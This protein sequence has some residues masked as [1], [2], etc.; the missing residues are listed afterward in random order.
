[1]S[2][3]AQLFASIPVSRASY[4]QPT[5]SEADQDSFI[6]VAL[7]SGIGLLVSLLAMLSGVQGV[8]S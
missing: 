5:P 4:A 1:M 6:A 3:V 2:K 8:W 7:F